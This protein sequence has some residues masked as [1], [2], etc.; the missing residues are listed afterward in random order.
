[1]EQLVLVRIQESNDGFLQCL[2]AEQFHTSVARSIHADGQCFQ[3]ENE[4]NLIFIFA[5][6][7]EY[8]AVK[9]LFN[10][11]QLSVRDILLV[12]RQ[13][14]VLLVDPVLNLLR[15]GFGPDCLLYLFFYS[16]FG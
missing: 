16:R 9:E 8:K 7:V 1:M 6:R 2:E 14:S 10:I 15:S 13:V 12:V 5:T 11:F 3:S 4:I